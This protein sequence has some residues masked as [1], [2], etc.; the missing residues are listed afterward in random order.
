MSRYIKLSGL[1]RKATDEEIKKFLVGCD[2]VGN[3]VIINNKTGK[4]SGDAVVK[5]RNKD[6]LENALKC[7]KKYLHNRFIVIEETDSEKYNRYIREI[8]QQVSQV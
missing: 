8:E 2:V 7:N 3:V 5:L 4:P 1:P 6:S